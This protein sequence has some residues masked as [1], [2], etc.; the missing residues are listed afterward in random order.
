[1]NEPAKNAKAGQAKQA[2]PG[3]L[4]TRRFRNPR[5]ALGHAVALLRN[6]EPFASYKFGRFSASLAEQIRRGHYFFTFQD[7]RLVGYIG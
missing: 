7:G 3:E 6:V 2:K 1:M 4:S 5:E